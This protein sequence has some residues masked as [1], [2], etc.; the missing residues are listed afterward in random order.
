MP[1]EKNG[2][3]YNTM[4]CRVINGSGINYCHNMHAAKTMIALVVMIEIV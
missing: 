4:H 1:Y 3:N 2:P